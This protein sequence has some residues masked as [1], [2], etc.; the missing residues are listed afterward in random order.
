MSLYRNDNRLSRRGRMDRI[1]RF[2]EQLDE[3]LAD[4]HDVFYDEDTDLPE[5]DELTDTQADR[6]YREDA[7]R[8]T[9]RYEK[10]L[11]L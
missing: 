10:G 8:A 6:E 7:D 9:D 11:G 4:A 3:R 1:A 5:P 2:L